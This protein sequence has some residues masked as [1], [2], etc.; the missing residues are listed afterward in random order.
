MQEKEVS[1]ALLDVGEPSRVSGPVKQH[2]A[3][4]AARLAHDFS[5][6]RIESALPPGDPFLDRFICASFTLSQVATRQEVTSSFTVVLEK[7]S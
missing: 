6:P 4:D 3:T 5:T 2:P 7:V 1:R